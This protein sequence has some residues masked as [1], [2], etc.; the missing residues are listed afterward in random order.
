[1]S[2]LFAKIDF[3][4][5]IKST[6]P[7]FY[8]S[9][10]QCGDVS[11]WQIV[12]EDG[13]NVFQ[14]ISGVYQ[15][16]G[17]SY[18][19]PSFEM[20]LKEYEIEYSFRCDTAISSSQYLFQNGSWYLSGT[21]IKVNGKTIQ[22]NI[23]SFKRDVW[24]KIKIERKNGT[25]K[26]YR[27]DVQTLEYD[28][29]LEELIITKYCSFYGNL[30]GNSS[31]KDL[32]SLKNITVN[33][34]NYDPLLVANYDQIA[35]GQSVTLSVVAEDLIKIKWGNGETSASITVTPDKTTIYTADVTTQNGI[36]SVQKTIVVKANKIYEQTAIKDEDCIF[37]INFLG[38][39]LNTIKGNCIDEN[40]INDPQLWTYGTIDGVDLLNLKCVQNTNVIYYRLPIFDGSDFPSAEDLELTYEAKVYID[41]DTWNDSE[42]ID[43][44]TTAS[45]RTNLN[46]ASYDFGVNSKRVVVNSVPNY[47]YRRNVIVTTDAIVNNI[48]SFKI[49]GWHHLAITAKIKKVDTSYLVIAQL[50]VDG[51][52]SNVYYNQRDVVPSVADTQRFTI[53]LNS[54]SNDGNV[55]CSEIIVT[56]GLK[57]SNDF[58]LPKDYFT[59]YT[60][61]AENVLPP[62]PD[63]PT[64]MYELEVINA[65]GTNAPVVAVK[66]ESETLSN[67]ICFAQSFSDFSAKDENGTL[68]E[69]QGTGIQINL[70][71]RTN[72]SGSALSFGIA[73]VNG[74]VMQ[75]A[76]EV[77]KGA[78]PCYLTVLQYMPFDTTK[79]YTSDNAYSPIYE[80]RLF[81]TACQITHKGA[82]ITAGWHDTLNAKFPYQR[83]TAKRFKGLRYVV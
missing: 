50:F 43:P 34:F 62:T 3:S 24:Y 26:I 67:P 65:N 70:P 63:E 9:P 27:D 45:T 82:T 5:G 47:D 74:E 1:M 55:Y 31:S 41:G 42:F 22:T 29:S 11:Q 23:G 78:N 51:K 17:L 73:S 56:K 14:K 46:R 48:S 8:A 57:Y 83:Y 59:S 40:C 33:E 35:Q 52:V 77:M 25:F 32:Y 60:T 68:R 71:E 76:D 2:R 10:Y 13:E 18:V 16:R 64:N 54:N 66:I 39:K 20:I 80:L 15:A 53:N 81:V 4:D 49:R 6:N 72:E 37:Y 12:Q 44:I 38:K 79:S 30:T 7:D 36:Y 58:E 75:I 21:S 61:V 19:S 69:F 28:D